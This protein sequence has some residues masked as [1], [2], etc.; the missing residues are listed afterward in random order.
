[1]QLLSDQFIT[2]LTLK[3]YYFDC[4]EGTRYFSSLDLSMGYHQIEMSPNDVSK[5]AFTVRTGQYAFKRM[6]FGLCGA[7]QSFQRVMASI[8]REQNWKHVPSVYGHN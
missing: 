3:N 5:T 4:L 1:M 7:P 8:L 2:Y 6:P